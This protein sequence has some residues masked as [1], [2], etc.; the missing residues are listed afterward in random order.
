MQKVGWSLSFGLGLLTSA[1]L[2]A[3]VDGAPTRFLRIADVHAQEKAPAASVVLKAP[4]VPDRSTVE[5]AEK[6][7]R[8]RE[9]MRRY[10]PH[11]PDL[12]QIN[13]P[14]PMEIVAQARFD[15]GAAGVSATDVPHV[16]AE[17]C[18]ATPGKK[19]ERCKAAA[20]SWSETKPEAAQSEIVVSCARS[21]EG[22]DAVAYLR[23]N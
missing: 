10:G 1:L 15:V 3:D 8:W 17:C 9:D 4:C 23:V 14:P 2:L 21:P 6:N 16:S 5:I 19:F 20:W 12:W 13:I 7:E 18:Y 11:E 22:V